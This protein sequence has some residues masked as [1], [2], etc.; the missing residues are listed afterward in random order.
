MFAATVVAALALAPMRGSTEANTTAPAGT[1]DPSPPT[2]SQWL[3]SRGWEC[4]GPGKYRKFCQGPRKA[5]APFGEAATLAKRLGLGT[6]RIVSHLILKPPPE[7]I[8][9]AAGGTPNQKAERAP[10]LL[11]PVPKGKF[12]RGFGR[13]RRGPKRRKRH[14]GIDIGA[15]KGTPVVAAK[16]GLVAYADNGV[17]GFGNLLVVVHPDGTVASYA[18]CSAIYVFP[19]QHVAQGNRVADVGHTGIA[20]GSHLHFEYRRRGRPRDP[21]PLFRNPP[22]DDRQL[23]RYRRRQRSI[24]LAR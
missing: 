15:P 13:V 10:H 11:W 22:E 18:H 7:A 20:R 17:R 2:V 24:T 12:W 6:D 19:G 21:L 14:R 1:S 23:E 9:V 4:M 3:P 16:A 8:R 5:P